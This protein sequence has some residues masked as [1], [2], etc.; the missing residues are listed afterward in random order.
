MTDPP[1]CPKPTRSQVR[2]GRLLVLVAA[3]LWSTS[4]FFAKAPIFLSWP[5]ED[6][7]VLF[8]F[9]RTLFASLV[10]LPLVRRPRWTPA[11]IPLALVY[12]AMNY[13]YM[14]ALTRTT[15][16]NAIWLQNTA[17]AWVLVVGVWLFGETADRRDWLFMPFGVAGV[18]LILLFEVQGSQ[19]DGILFGLLAGLTYA[20]VILFVR[21]LKREDAAWLIALSNL[22]TA[23]IFLP[24][25]IR[26]GVWPQGNQ[27]FFLATFGI[28]QLGLP[29]LLFAKGMHWI[30]G[31]QAAA[32]AML[33][34]VLVPVWVFLAWHHSSSYQPPQ[35]WTFVG[36]AMILAGLAL[37]YRQP[38]RTK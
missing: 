27:I 7:G 34:P 24:S 22:A 35:W 4:G 20:G 33:E 29:Y 37:R 30:P 10:L 13:A 16:A 18:G 21:H 26:V 8:A 1:Y 9:W 6:R 38:P 25:V 15:A 31:H 5:V 11:L 14:C 2:T 23:A 12:A 28:F 17:P 19:L 32:I 36:G 3:V